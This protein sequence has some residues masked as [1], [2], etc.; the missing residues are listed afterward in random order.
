MGVS[1]VF[2]QAFFQG[3]LPALKENFSRDAGQAAQV[4]LLLS[5]GLV[6]RAEAE[7]EAGPDYLTF[8]YSLRQEK[9]RAVIPYDSIVA[10][11]LIPAEQKQRRPA[12]LAP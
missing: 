11:N 7:L 9:R 10:V 2:N 8:P 12:G 3:Q 6:F 5:H 4:E 1:V